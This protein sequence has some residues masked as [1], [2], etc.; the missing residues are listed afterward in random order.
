LF[1]HKLG[2]AGVPVKYLLLD[3]PD[4]IF[5]KDY[6]ALTR[7]TSQAQRQLLSLT[8]EQQNPKIKNCPL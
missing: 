6:G 2:A 1:R 7:N 4:T 5:I 8:V 3:M